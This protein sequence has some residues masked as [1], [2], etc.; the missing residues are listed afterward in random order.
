[1]IKATSIMGEKEYRK[2]IAGE[3]IDIQ[4]AAL[5]ALDFGADQR[6]IVVD[7]L[8]KK[9]K[10]IDKDIRDSATLFE[11]I[12]KRQEEFALCLYYLSLKDMQ[13][14]GEIVTD[15]RK[16]DLAKL[17]GVDIEHYNRELR[18]FVEKKKSMLKVV[19]G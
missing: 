8:R 1:M 10:I 3:I 6:D 4:A 5:M 13:R 14:H 11:K 9:F 15:S 12:L 7:V 18:Q 16:K 2:V 17:L 19:K